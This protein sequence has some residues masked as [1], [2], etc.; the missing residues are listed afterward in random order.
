M[1]LQNNLS[2]TFNLQELRQ[3]AQYDLRI[4]YETFA[5]TKPV[6]VMELLTYMQRRGRLYELAEVCQRL[7]PHVQW[8]S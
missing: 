6:F 2:E 3:M 7:R 1:R 5:D 8:V 4:D